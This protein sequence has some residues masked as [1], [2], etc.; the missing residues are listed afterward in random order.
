MGTFPTP[1]MTGMENV[2]LYG[3]N[4]GGDSVSAGAKPDLVSAY[5]D[6]ASR[7]PNVTYTDA[8]DIG[9]LTLA[10]GVY[11]SP[12][13]LFLTGEV[14]L[15][16]GGDPNA[17][18]IF[19]A[20]STLVTASD[21]VVTL[22]GGAK[23]SNVFWQVGSSATLGT[24][25]HFTGTILALTSITATTNAAINGRLWARN[26]AVTLDHNNISASSASPAW[27]PVPEPSSLLAGLLLSAG[28]LRRRRTPARI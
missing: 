16:A 15:D 10:S 12:S 8:F 22:M 14:I 18:W 4:H 26:G 2:I 24:G 11:N 27:S 5:T 6:A 7:T 28:I 9:G 20:G 23:A 19:Q 13:S 3:V 1:A 25:T 17:V 21:S